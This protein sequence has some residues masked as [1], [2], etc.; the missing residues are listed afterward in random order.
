MSDQ[1]TRGCCVDRLSRQRLSETRIQCPVTQLTV[2]ATVGAQASRGF[3]QS[4]NATNLRSA[5][6]W[7]FNSPLQPAAQ[8]SQSQGAMASL[9]PF[10]ALTRK[11]RPTNLCSSEPSGNKTPCSGLQP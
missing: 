10:N 2:Y 6:Q 11:V 1:M 5:G 9:W 3:P 8:C 7:A 4:K